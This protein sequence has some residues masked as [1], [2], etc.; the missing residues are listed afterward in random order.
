M[1]RPKSYI[2]I[3]LNP[4]DYYFGDCYTRIRTIL[5]SCVSMTFWHPRLLVGGMC[6]YMLPNRGEN[7]DKDELDG[8]YGEDAMQLMLNEIQQAG[9]RHWEFE[10]KLFG[11]ADMFPGIYER[12]KNTPGDRNI[13]SARE[14][15]EQHGFHCVAEHLGGNGHRSV[16]F[17]VWSGHVWVKHQKPTDFSESN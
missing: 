8:R 11:G 10:V 4:G 7:R 1:L 3:F 12:S 2:E 14:L 9:A 6:H 5:G 16:I 17:D 15:V 13:L